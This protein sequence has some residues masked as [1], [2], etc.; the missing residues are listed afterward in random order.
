MAIITFS[1]YT[2][3]LI[4]ALG[5]GFGKPFGKCG[6][7]WLFDGVVLVHP[8][9]ANAATADTQTQQAVAIDWESCT[10]FYWG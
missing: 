8:I 3:S 2:D 7:R 9:Q 10:S 6:S 4:I 5:C 1:D